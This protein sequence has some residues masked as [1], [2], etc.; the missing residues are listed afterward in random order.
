MQIKQM[1]GSDDYLMV[2]ATSEEVDKRYLMGWSP[3]KHSMWWKVEDNLVNRIVLGMPILSAAQRQEIKVSPMPHLFKYQYDDVI[4]LCGR[5]NALNANP[6][7]LGKTLETIMVLR[8]NGLMDRVLILCPK[9]VTYQWKEEL[10]NWW[11]E[12]KGKIDVL[13]THVGSSGI[14]IMNYERAITKKMR[15]QLNRFRWEVVICDE[16]HRIKSRTSVRTKLVHSL[17]AGRRFALTGTP[18]LNKPNDLWSLLNWL[19]WRY[20]GKSYH[21]FTNYFCDVEDGFFGPSI[22]G[23]T[24][25]SAK[26]AILVK[27]LNEVGVYNENTMGMGKRVITVNLPMDAKQKKLYKDA[28]NLVFE[29]LPD[30]MTIPNGAVLL[31]RL[32]QITSN[33]HL[34]EPTAINPKFLWILDTIEDNP[35]EKFVVFTR[36][37]QTLQ[38]L[39]KRIGPGRCV[40]YEG[41][42]S[43]AERSAAIK[44]FKTDPAIRCLIG[45]IGALGQGVD[46]LQHVSRTAIFIERDWSPALMQQAEDRLNRIGQKHQVLVYCLDCPN[47]VDKYVG[48]VNLRKR[49]DIEK[50]LRGE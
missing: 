50:V 48:R 6:M 15:P 40:V 36:F 24:K 22:K 33:P 13:P 43:A 20:S 32:Q 41:Q 44:Q 8:E 26:E 17:P 21:S 28:K 7:G 11:P 35:E 10:E 16:A 4:K 31:M 3:I 25:N 14:I 23:L 5:V 47:T 2:L 46:G 18:V 45:T 34:F 49:E 9:S 27:L 1:P 37:S 19:D 38:A 12:T 29:N 39:Q 42:M 30:T